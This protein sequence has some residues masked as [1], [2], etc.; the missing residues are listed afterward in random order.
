MTLPQI[1]VLAV[2]GLP[3]ILVNMN[4]LRL[5]VAALLSAV[6]LG[7]LPALGGGMLGAPH[8]PGA[9]EEAYRAV[10]WQAVFLIAGMYAVSRAMV[11]TGLADLVGTHVLQLLIPFGALGL[12]AG[13]YIL[14]SALTQVMGGQV[15]I[16]VTG[17]I[18]I[19][20]AI[21]ANTSPQAI[22]VAAAIG[23]SAS[24]FTPIAHPVNI[25]MIGPANYTFG[26]FFRI[27]WPLT[28]VCFLVLLVG[29]VCFWHL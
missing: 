14:T 25:L 6:A 26:D 28:I 8:T 10:E 3:L 22:A 19:S 23:C 13:A 20:A 11:A 9:M 18:L 27:G 12:A 5:D 7:T 21:S 16:L 17:P 2:V 15:A 4:R 29:L 1:L 24:F